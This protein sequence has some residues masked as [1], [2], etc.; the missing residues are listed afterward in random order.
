M[1]LMP[2]CTSTFPSL[3]LLVVLFERKLHPIRSGLDWAFTNLLFLQ[4]IFLQNINMSLSQMLTKCD[5][6]TTKM[7]WN[8]AT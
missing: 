1:G 8:I 7:L 2:L 3:F 5:Y 6:F 4:N